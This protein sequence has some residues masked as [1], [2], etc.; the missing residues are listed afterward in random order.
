ML[1]GSTLAAVVSDGG[2][3]KGGDRG[4][5]RNAERRA[6]YA[7][8][9]ARGSCTRCD[10]RPALDGDNYCRP[11]GRRV[12]RTQR[13][14]AKRRRQVRRRRR[15]CRDCGRK[16][17]TTRCLACSIRQGRSGGDRGVDRQTIQG[18][19][20]RPETDGY[21]R[22]RFHGKA[23]RGPPTKTDRDSLE[24]R[25]AMQSLSRA[26]A[27]CTA[28]GVAQDLS[29]QDR[30]AADLAWLDQVA[31]VSRIADELLDRNRYARRIAKI[32]R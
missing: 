10:R 14:A 20:T 32:A 8:R 28:V 9:L 27:G 26:A 12:R 1:D 16:S 11:C 25:M 24:L 23:R 15:E 29:T 22:R 18:H 3:Q 2:A 17:K 19:D 5:D 31:L 13:I 6:E 4:V 30:E 21:Q 7:D